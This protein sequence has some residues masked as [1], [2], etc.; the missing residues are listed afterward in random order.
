M[1]HS[2]SCRET[3]ALFNSKVSQRFRSIERVA[4]RKL[5]QLH[6]TTDLL[7]L[8]IPPGNHLELLKGDRMGWYSIRIN[9]QWRICFMWKE[10]G[11][12]SVAIVDY[13]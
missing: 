12:F 6:A 9:Q 11:A 2:F 10:D 7:D 8:R 4:R 3:E 5:L 1:I 13:H